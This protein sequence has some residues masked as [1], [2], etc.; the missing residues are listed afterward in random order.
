MLGRDPG[1][2]IIEVTDAQ[3]LAAERHQRRG[4]EA[5]AL[6]TDDGGFHDVEACLQTPVRL[7][8]HAVAQIIDAQRLVCFREPQLPGGA[9]IFDRG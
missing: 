8:A 4:A 3:I 9:C 6:S 7:Q 1:R 2:A 5:K